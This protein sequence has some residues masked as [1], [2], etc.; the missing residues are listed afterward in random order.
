[1]CSLHGCLCVE[2]ASYGLG[3][4]SN[5]HTL[6]PQKNKNI[7]YFVPGNSHVLLFP[8]TVL[9]ESLAQD[10]TGAPA[11]RARCFKKIWS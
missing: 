10:G 5:Y 6:L 3:H 9:C 1:M 11:E 7:H 2:W 8:T 4:L